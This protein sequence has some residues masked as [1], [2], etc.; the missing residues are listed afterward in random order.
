MYPYQ[1]SP[2]FAWGHWNGH[3][4]TNLRVNGNAR[5]GFGHKDN[6]Y[7]ASFYGPGNARHS[8]TGLAAD[9]ANWG[10]AGGAVS[11]GS[12]SEFNDQCRNANANYKEGQQ[13]AGGLNLITILPYQN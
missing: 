4:I 12:A 10:T 7:S 5:R 1:N 11:Q 2:Q 6:A 13:I 3:G 9:Q 8:M